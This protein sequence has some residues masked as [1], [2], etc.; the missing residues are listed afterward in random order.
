MKT[1]TLVIH[2]GRLV[3]VCR[4]ED[5]ATWWIAPLRQNTLEGISIRQVDVFGEKSHFESVELVLCRRKLVQ[6]CASLTDA[7]AWT[8]DLPAKALEEL[9][10]EVVDVYD[11]P[12]YLKEPN[13]PPES[14]EDPA[15]AL[16]Y[17]RE[18]TKV[19]YY[20]GFAI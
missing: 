13:G 7:A 19:E 20:G 11:L 15:D 18:E 17:N 10:Y 3:Q 14:G 6:V 16:L 12:D 5:A 1:V 8:A 2:E 9:T 4:N